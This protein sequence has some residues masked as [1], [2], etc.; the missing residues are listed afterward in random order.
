MKKFISI[1]ILSVF[2]FS[3]CAFKADCI[4]APDLSA[5]CAALMCVQTGE[6]LYQRNAY[7]CRSMASTT[8]IMTSLIAL[9]E[10][11]PN[12]EIKVNDSMLNV[13]GTSMGL[14][15]GD[16]VTLEGLVYGMLLQS[17]NDAANTVAV[18][19]G[20]SCEN[21]SKMMNE[22]AKKIGMKSTNFVTPSGL[23]DDNH[24]S[25]AYD[26]ALLGCEAVK[27][28]EFLYICS[29]KSASVYYGNPPYKRMLTNHNKMLWYYNGALGI[30]TG[31]T[32]KSGRCLV[33]CAEK[34]G[35]MLVAVTLN[36]PSDWSDHKKLFDYGFDKVQSVKECENNLSVP[37]TGGKTKFVKAQSEG[38]TL[39]NKNYTKR[40]FSEK[41]LYAPV[42]QGTVI[43]E[44]R[45]YC[46]GK[47]IAS[48]PITATENIE[49]LPVENNLP[50][51][52]G[53]IEKIKQFFK[54]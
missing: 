6:L 25:T 31:F 28:P 46:Q 43:G 32:K 45:Y 5:E 13:E 37:V 34:D 22:R 3:L 36:A 38:V 7:E 42:K 51:K 15:V 2:T 11:T 52:Q 18:A 19:L 30:K 14:M 17:G 10:H 1:I 54:F 44:V 48:A 47:E 29:K 26:M 41:F 23:D 53:F 16:S 33:S 40:I 24:H 21:F 20:G 27:N 12:R 35:V 4:D 39:C 50:K 9:E 49:A 8:K